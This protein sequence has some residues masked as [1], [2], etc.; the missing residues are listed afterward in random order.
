[1]SPFSSDQIEQQKKKILPTHLLVYPNP[2]LSASD[3]QG[4]TIIFLLLLISATWIR[5]HG[6]PQVYVQQDTESWACIHTEIG[7]ARVQRYMC[8]RIRTPCPI[9][10][11]IAHVIL[12]FQETS[13][14]RTQTLLFGLYNEHHRHP[15]GSSHSIK[16]HM[17]SEPLLQRTSSCTLQKK[18][19]R[20]WRQQAP[21]RLQ[22][23]SAS[24]S[25]RNLLGTTLLYGEHKFFLLF[26]GRVCLEFSMDPQCSHPRRSGLRNQ[27][28]PQKKQKTRPT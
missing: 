28:N 24:L 19:R 21:R 15:K 27:T 9:R 7:R 18:F 8:S 3:K 20:S 4:K 14:Y 2:V 17:V 1:M 12:S 23:S 6:R 11:I 5:N 16:F 25:W 10:V 22:Q 13:L 26:A